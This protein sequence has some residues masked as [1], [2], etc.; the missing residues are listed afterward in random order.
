MIYHGGR[1][2]SC[3]FRIADMEEKN[4]ILRSL[5]QVEKLLGRDDV[6][7]YIPEIGRSAVTGIVRGELAAAR[8]R[9]LGGE[10]FDIEGSVA[11]ILALCELKRR[12]KLRRVINGTGIAIHTNLGRSP[13]GK[14]LLGR[15]AG[16]LAGYCNLEYD[17]PGKKR[18]KRGGFSEELIADLTG[19]EAALIVNNNAAAVFLILSE[20]ARGREVIVS[21]GELVQIGGGF[22]IPDIMRQ[23][24]ARL[25]EAGTTNI[26]TLD[27]FRGAVTDETAM[28]FSCHRSNF[29]MTGFT[30]CPALSELASLRNEGILFV[31]DL[32]S[33]NL[34]DDRRLPRPFEPTVRWALAQGPDLVSFSG[35]KLLGGCQAGIVVGRRDLVERLR[36]NPLMRMV[37]VDKISYYLLQETLIRHVNGETEALALWDSLLQEKKAVAARVS[38][39]L[40]MIRDA[41]VKELLRR[42]E[43]RCA[44]GGGAMPG[45]D[46][47]SLGVSVEIPGVGA[48]DIH[49][50]FLAAAVPVVGA[51]SGGRYII[52]FFTVT[53]D[54]L[55][56][57]AS[58]VETVIS[59]YRG[60]K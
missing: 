29:T 46:M 1:F 21:R 31:R 59:H 60:S 36:K 54:D 35:D 20:F 23:S 48:D 3:P 50:S 13:L 22:R 7:S 42:V 26:T 47:E 33:G 24:G 44:I 57:L 34:T 28:V 55:G 2:D 16:E 18:G 58:A 14:Q 56:D 43:T 37:R 9:A 4:D 19:A 30:E 25:V 5:P 32:G 41:S 17:I 45:V 52:D 38:R 15:L 10:P 27:D 12:T 49:E 11:S 8:E 51:V 53:E 40:R 6:R 39:F